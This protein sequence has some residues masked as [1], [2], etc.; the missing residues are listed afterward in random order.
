MGFGILLMEVV[1]GLTVSCF[2][3]LKGVFEEPDELWRRLDRL[4]HP[5]THNF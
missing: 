4:P 1:L 3:A 5:F 2:A